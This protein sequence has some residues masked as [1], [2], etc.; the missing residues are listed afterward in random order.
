MKR[1]CQSSK[2]ES[3]ESSLSPTPRTRSALSIEKSQRGKRRVEEKER[4]RYPR[5]EFVFFE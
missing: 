1:S 5:L 2:Q 4:E 3:G